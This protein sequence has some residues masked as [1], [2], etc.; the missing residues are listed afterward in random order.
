MGLGMRDGKVKLKAKRVAKRWCISASSFLLTEAA[1][2]WTISEDG[3]VL[4]IGDLNDRMVGNEGCCLL[5]LQL[6][7]HL[8]VHYFLIFLPGQ[9]FLTRFSV[10]P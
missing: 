7:L 5:Y 8:H 1:V 6:Y 3:F 10:P 4:R 9:L 2:G